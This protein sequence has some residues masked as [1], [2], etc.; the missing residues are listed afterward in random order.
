MSHVFNKLIFKKLT[1][2]KNVSSKGSKVFKK[3]SA[4]VEA[5]APPII[6]PG[7]SPDDFNLGWLGLMPGTYR[8]TAT[9]LAPSLKIGESKHSNSE[10][11]K[12]E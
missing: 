6:I 7:L 12:V 5:P 1:S 8:I 11:Y 3:L 9:T 10:E 4:E 2:G